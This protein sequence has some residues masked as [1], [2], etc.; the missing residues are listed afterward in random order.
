MKLTLVS[1]LIVSLSGCTL[2]PTKIVYVDKPIPY[3]PAPAE[4]PACT[5]YVDQLQP[6]DITEPG[7]VAQAYKLDMT[8]YRT[9]DK[10]LRHIIGGY[11]EISKQNGSVD[12]MLKDATATIQA[13]QPA[14]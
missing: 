13:S 1:L 14:K 2:L 10:T 3:C 12:Q 8:C 11:V 4:V 9:N 5:N 6:S 7:K